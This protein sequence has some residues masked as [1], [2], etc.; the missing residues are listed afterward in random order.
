MQVT[1]AWGGSEPRQ[2]IQALK[3]ITRKREIYAT[4]HDSGTFSPSRG[5]TSS[6]EP[7]VGLNHFAVDSYR[8]LARGNQ[9]LILSPFSISTALAMVL[10]GAR[11]WTASEMATVLHRLQPDPNYDAALALLVE[12]LTGTANTGRNELSISNGLWVQRGFPILTDFSTT[13]ESR[14]NAPLTS[15]DF[16]AG[17]EQARTAINAWTAQ[18]TNGKIPELYAAGSLDPRT[19]VD[20]IATV[21]T[22]RCLSQSANAYRSCVKVWKPAHVLCCSIRGYGHEHLRRPNIDSGRVRTHHR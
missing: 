8:E 17:A 1:I 4:F 13:I 18:H 6:G 7:P 15:L 9:N 20:S 11:G 12:E 19:P 2:R 16:L 22:S 3:G 21:F 14:Y 10:D 5:N